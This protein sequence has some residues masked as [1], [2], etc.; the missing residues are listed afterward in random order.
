MAAVLRPDQI[1]QVLVEDFDQYRKPDNSGGVGI[2][3]D[4]LLLTD[5]ER[6]Q[7]Q[8]SQLQLLFYRERVGTYAETMGAY[9]A[10]AANEWCAADAPVDI[11]DATA[12]YTLRVLSKT[13]FGI[14]TDDSREAVQAGAHAIREQS[15]DAPGAVT[16][17]EWLPTPG[18]RRYR[19]G[20][21]QLESVGS[22]VLDEQES[23]ADSFSYY[24]VFQTLKP[25]RSILDTTLLCYRYD[26]IGLRYWATIRR[27]YL[28]SA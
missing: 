27:G 6:W 10:A 14:E 5:G 28:G 16:L 25:V 1:E 24:R 18:N 22:G 11:V 15:N 8:R 7:Q 19:R 13:L 4:G 2:L 3:G 26:V 23:A 17:P 20:I 12:E 9:A 21:S